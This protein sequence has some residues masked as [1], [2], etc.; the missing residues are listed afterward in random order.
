MQ[1]E[2]ETVDPSYSRGEREGMHACF[3]VFRQFRKNPGDSAA[4]KRKDLPFNEHYPSQTCLLSN[5]T[6]AIH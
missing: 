3:L 1:Q 5:L 6:Y 2:L 4:Q